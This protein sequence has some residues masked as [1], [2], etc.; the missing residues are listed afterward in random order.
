MSSSSSTPAST[1]SR[2]AGGASSFTS[3]VPS[4]DCAC[5]DDDGALDY[6]PTRVVPRALNTHC[7][8]Y[9]EDQLCTYTLVNLHLVNVAPRLTSPVV[10]ALELANSLLTSGPA[11][12][13]NRANSALV[14]PPTQIAFINNLTIHPK[15]TSR[16]ETPERRE[17]ASL[18]L[19]YL[20]SVLEAAG[21][22]N[23]NLAA[24]FQFNNNYSPRPRRRTVHPSDD[25]YSDDFGD[26]SS[27]DENGRVVGRLGN[28]ELLWNCGHDFWSVIG[29]AFNCSVAHP[30]RWRWWRVWL[31]FM[32]RAMEEDWVARVRMDEVA[33]SRRGMMG[34]FEFDALYGSLLATYFTQL[35]GRTNGVKWIVRALFADGHQA[36]MLLFKEVFPAETRDMPRGRKKRKREVELDLENF[37]Y[38]DYGDTDD[39]L[40][41]SPGPGEELQSPDRPT[42]SSRIN[43]EQEP[44]K[45]EHYEENRE[46]VH[47]LVPFRLRLMALLSRLAYAMPKLFAPLEDLHEQF[48]L[49]MKGLPLPL[50]AAMLNPIANPMVALLDPTRDPAVATESYVVLLKELLVLFLPPKFH[51]PARVDAAADREGRVTQV[52]AEKCFVHYAA[53]GASAE[54]NAR[55]SVL[56]ESLLVYLFEKGELKGSSALREAVTAGI[57]ARGKKAKVRRRRG[58]PNEQDALAKGMLDSS[59]EMIMMVL[60]AV[61]C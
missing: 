24:A 56:V 4:P 10:H 15:H 22:V 19:A 43:T 51:D 27:D 1:A 33:N 28:E 6:R 12:T 61:G 35:T 5:E 55:L 18:A 53:D 23:A 41:E 9:F 45:Y 14:L 2:A 26:D 21:P 40:E 50:F 31:D 20:E 13:N 8:I 38:A 54:D 7:R 3:V 47:A 48:A 59:A 34:G 16:P 32:L 25:S 49:S 52:M 60:D 57:E 42:R 30:A 58:A 11:S 46:A 44:D 39:E 29:W 36:S 17:I 37:E